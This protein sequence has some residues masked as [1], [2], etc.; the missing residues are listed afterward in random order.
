MISDP[1]ARNVQ[2]RAREIAGA[3]GISLIFP[4]GDGTDKEN[5]SIDDFLQMNVD[6]LL[7]ASERYEQRTVLIGNLFRNSTGRGWQGEWLRVADGE[8]TESEYDSNTLDEALQMG[9]NALVSSEA[10]ADS[11]Y[12]YGGPAAS[13]TE[14]LVWV[15]SVSSLA[16]YASLIRFFEAV[17][18]VGTVYPKEV[19]DTSMTFAVLPRSALRDV[20]NAMPSQRW[21]RRSAPTLVEDAGGLAQNADLAL[22]I[23]R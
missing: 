20:E 4:S 17:P 15:G 10:S 19:G 11:S 21:L 9:M 3:L 12:R 16:D 23:D 2:S 5:V 7:A 13:G 18:N 1:E 14:G 6:N 8:Q 22:E